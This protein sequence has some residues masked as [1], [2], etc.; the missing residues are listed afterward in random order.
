METTN[1]RASPIEGG[2][3]RFTVEK[4]PA[5]NLLFSAVSFILS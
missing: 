4:S 3:S 2:A 5:E 1:G